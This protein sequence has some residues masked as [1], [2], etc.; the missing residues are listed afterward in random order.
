MFAG[1]EKC[2]RKQ[3][4]GTK[5]VISHDPISVKKKKKDAIFMSSCEWGKCI[6]M[7]GSGEGAWE[8]VRRS[9]YLLLFCDFIFQS[10]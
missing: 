7:L 5:R 6:K 9:A 2:P 10:K 8:W 3:R 1:W 4:N